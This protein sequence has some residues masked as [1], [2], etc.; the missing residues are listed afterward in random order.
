MIIIKAFRA[1]E[2]EELCMKYAR[3][4]QIVLESFN[5]TNLTTNNYDWAYNPDVYVVV[6]ISEKNGNLLGGIR[7]QVANQKE[8]LPR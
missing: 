7:I 1:I 8:K 3:A 4:H 5:L 6:A 2:D